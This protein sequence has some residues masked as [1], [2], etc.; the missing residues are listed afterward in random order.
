[1]NATL[2]PNAGD[3]PSRAWA[4]VAVYAVAMAW[5]EA[6]VV[7]DLRTLVNRLEP[8]RP[9]PLPLVPGVGGAELIRE[10]ATLLMLMTVGWLAGRGWRRRFAF[11]ALGF[12]VWDIFYYVFLRLLTGWPRS[13]WDW[14]ILFLLPL[15]WW[16]PVLAPVMI[17]AL[18][19]AGGVLVGCYDRPERPL[20]PRRPTLILGGLGALLAL[21]VFMADALRAAPGGIE[22]VRQVLPVRFAWWLF[23][24]AWLAMSAPVLEVAWQASRRRPDPDRRA[25]RLST[26]A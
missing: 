23:L 13:L 5:V 14:D 18:L 26:H 20:W 3:R 24:P 9:D 2:D 8:Y 21:G 12:G 7:L 17:A 1:M 25:C 4:A 6:A 16:G 22:A 10:A 11:F 15:P 19:V